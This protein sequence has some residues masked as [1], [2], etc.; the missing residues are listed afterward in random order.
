MTVPEPGP[1]RRARAAGRVIGRSV[2][3][4]VIANKCTGGRLP[5]LTIEAF[6]TG[7]IMTVLLAGVVLAAVAVFGST[8][9]SNR[10]FRLLHWF[11]SPETRGAPG[12]RRPPG[13]GR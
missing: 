5:V 13:S 7:I 12:R 2:A 3:A 10:A 8:R 9:S 6:A 1:A 11:K 4:G